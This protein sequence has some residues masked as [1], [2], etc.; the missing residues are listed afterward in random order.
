MKAKGTD[1]ILCRPHLLVSA[2]R[3]VTFSLL[4]QR[5]SNQRETTPGIRVWLRQT[6]LA[7]A[8]F[9]GSSRWA[10]P[11]PSLLVWHPCQTPLCAAPLLGL[12]TGPGDRG[13]CKFVG[14]VLTAK[15][16][17]APVLSATKH[18]HLR[19]SGGLATHN[20]HRASKKPRSVRLLRRSERGFFA[21]GWR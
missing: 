4:V 13:A 9:R 6:S 12:L 14:A 1:L 2:L 19:R 16:L 18:N 15:L 17:T 8:L 3:R 21:R 20:W 5:E 11:G 7:P 10:V